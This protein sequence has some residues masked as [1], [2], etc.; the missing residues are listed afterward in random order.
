MPLKSSTFALSVSMPHVAPRRLQLLLL[1][2]LANVFI[3]V[4]FSSL[5][6]LQL[7]PSAIYSDAVFASP[8]EPLIPVSQFEVS[9]RLS[10]VYMKL[11][12]DYHYGQLPIPNGFRE[13]IDAIQLTNMSD[14]NAIK[15]GSVIY[16]DSYFA[17]GFIIE[18]L[19]NIKSR[20]VLVTGDSG[21]CM[22]NC[23]LTK[24]GVLK[25][26]Q[27]PHL[28]YWHTSH[29]NGTS[30][31]SH[32]MGCMPIGIDQH[33]TARSDL[34]K[35]YE[36]GIGLKDGVSQ[37]ISPWEDRP[38]KYL[39]ASFQVSTNPKARAPLMELLC[40]N[41][42]S[43]PH[44]K[45]KEIKAL[46][47]VTNCFYKKRMNKLDFY[48]NVLSQAR[49]VVSPAGQ[50]P[51]CYRTYETLFL[52]GYPIVKTSTIDVL[53]K[54]L[55][56]LI[57]QEWEDLTVELLEHTYRDF[58]SRKFDFR[59]L[60]VDYWRQKSVDM[61]KPTH[62]PASP[63]RPLAVSAP[64]RSLLTPRRLHLRTILLVA[65][66]VACALFV[67]FRSAS[68]V[69]QAA[70]QNDSGIPKPY[71]SNATFEFSHE[72]KV[73]VKQMWQESDR[74]SHI[75]NKI[76][77]DYYYGRSP[78]AHGMMQPLQKLRISNSTDVS[79]FKDGFVLY[80]DSVSAAEFVD[81]ILPR[82]KSRFVLVT[83]DSNLCM[84]N[85]RLT[86]FGTMSIVQN[87]YL[88]YWWTSHCHGIHI[89]DHKI[90]C[91]PLGIDQHGSSRSAMQ[92]AYQMGLGL[93]QG[94]EQRI[95]PWEERPER[96][97][98]SSFQ[99][100]TNRTAR[101]PVHDLFCGK[102]EPAVPQN[103][104]EKV[105]NVR[106]ITHCSFQKGI[107]KLDF[108]RDTLSKSLFVLSPPGA[109]PDCYRTYEALFL[110][111][112][113]IVKSS[114][115]DVLFKDLP[116]L[117]VNEWRDITVELLEQTYREFQSRK[118]DFSTLYTDYWRQQFRAP[119]RGIS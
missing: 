106:S 50:G 58:Q 15:P 70:D 57:V 5:D 39:L 62:A 105:N 101:L 71:L 80:V 22:P 45:S 78:I 68:S 118:F 37:R 69:E 41:E 81:Q 44:G 108:Y 83:G 63:R 90:G 46:R 23:R 14:F 31:A 42:T 36:A 86:R 30:I 12:S 53:F 9:S 94:I 17:G 97:L 114:D 4:T 102:K 113:P 89:A 117:I 85:C 11:A 20:F 87:P 16:V 61:N 92:R 3:F 29:C 99:I 74:L 2:C 110:G 112:Y 34:Q 93:V 51:D 75:Y 49:F 28:I 76:N 56:V 104:L 27:N 107:K 25:V 59:P 116:V 100:S 48:T 32:K 40:G 47:A 103:L 43:I 91:M 19:P 67:W 72:P 33:G 6:L 18:I 24:T 35:A 119:L 64:V 38:E 82:I 98:L 52:G 13:S 88:I 21:I 1:V 66:L 96:Y 26:T 10:H 65:N 115:L 109:G 55:P 95:V 79:K 60:Y 111:A 84:P 8:K 77:C 7:Y 73:R 54:D